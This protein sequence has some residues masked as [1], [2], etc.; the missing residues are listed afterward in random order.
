[1][2]LFFRRSASFGPLR[3]NFSK[4]GVGASV[5]VKGARLTVSPK[6]TTYITVGSGGLY[7]RRTLSTG[8]KHN[9]SRA[10]VPV[11]PE[12][13]SLDE[14]RTAD[15]EELLVSS[16]SELVE[17]LNQRARMF[18]PASI[19]FVLGAICIAIGLRQIVESV[20]SESM[21]A[22]PSVSGLSDVSRQSNQTDEYALLLARFGQPSTVSVSQKG[23]VPVRLATYA[24]AHVAIV[25]VPVR[26]VDAYSY[27]QAHKADI[28]PAATP[29]RR[30]GSARPPQPAVPGCDASGSSASTIVGY[31]N[32]SGADIDGVT[33]QRSLADLGV[34]S[35]ALPSVQITPAPQP[36]KRGAKAVSPTPYTISYDQEAFVTEQRHI[37]E[38]K[39]TGRRDQ[40]MGS[41][42][43]VGSLL[44]FVPGFLVH[45]KNKESR[46][47]RLVYDLSGSVSAQNEKMKGALDHLAG[48]DRIWR[49]D[50]RSAVTDW[51]RNAG[52]AYNLKRQQ[53]SLRTA[54]PPRVESNV[55][56]VCI[57][58]GKLKMFFL[59]DQVLYW[60]RGTFASIEYKD[61]SFDA[62]STRFIEEQ[63]QTSD[64][65]QV[66]STWRYV[67]KDG[68]PD[69]RFN[70]NR[71]LPVMLYGVVTAV[72]SS[73][74]NLILHTSS[75]AA[76]NSF[77]TSF[78]AFQGDRSGLQIGEGSRPAGESGSD[79]AIR[80]FPENIRSAMELLGVDGKSTAEQVNAAYRQKAQ[81][82]HP[83]K[84][85]G[86]GPELQKLA[87]ERMKAINAA[88]LAL[89]NYLGAI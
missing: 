8:A 83:D 66:G 11:A 56:P 52:A 25:F 78:K 17:N 40:R 32:G 27:F 5:G 79:Q 48:S 20:S 2:G 76:A 86:L 44:L 19:L 15:V 57:D 75:M 16:R 12:Q 87:D 22:L 77:A 10:E 82:Y 1:M 63:R 45:R 53:I 34:K 47:N 13:P 24:G 21:Q 70:N 18:N 55:I 23:S 84:V 69:R 6:G 64:S 37:A 59:P 14:I 71:Q 49:L 54:L 29:K 41:C 4:S 67:R 60:Q 46:V 51:K 26:C 81:M 58:L 89:R 30:K 50:S 74:L 43:L 61:L 62:G 73:G 31:Q 9:S 88:D 85:V 38:A 68:G 39:A 7:Y 35:E 80:S 36:A 65:Q 3:F 28:P 72:S 33:A 42:F